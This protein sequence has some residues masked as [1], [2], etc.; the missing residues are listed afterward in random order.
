MIYLKGLFVFLTIGMASLPIKAQPQ[1]VNPLTQWNCLHDIAC[2]QQAIAE[3]ADVNAKSKGSHEDPVLYRASQLGRLDVVETLWNAG[4]NDVDATNYFGETALE[5][6]IERAI[7]FRINHTSI[8]ARH[9][10]VARFLLDHGATPPDSMSDLYPK[11]Q[12]L[13]HWIANTR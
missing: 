5:I 8:S 12:I 11:L 7:R 2:V 10:E 9:V 13:L 6:A 1:E 3:G 4:I